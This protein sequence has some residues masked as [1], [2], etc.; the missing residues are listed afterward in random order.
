MTMLTRALLNRG[1]MNV[2]AVTNSSERQTNKIQVFMDVSEV[3][4]ALFGIRNYN[5]FIMHI[6]I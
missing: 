3:L 1:A 4:L 6:F 5:F 2:V